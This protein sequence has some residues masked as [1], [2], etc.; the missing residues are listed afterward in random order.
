MVD[1]ELV[2][3]KE[4]EVIKYKY[5]GY[6]ITGTFYGDLDINKYVDSIIKI[7]EKPEMQK[8]L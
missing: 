1:P 2:K 6:N 7:S 3:G 8:Y 4:K 5:K